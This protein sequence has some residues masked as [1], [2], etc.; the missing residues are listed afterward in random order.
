[1]LHKL[2]YHVLHKKNLSSTYSLCLLLYSYCVRVRK[3][4]P[5]MLLDVLL[6]CILQL[7]PKQDVLKRMSSLKTKTYR[8]P[9]PWCDPSQ[10]VETDNC[11][12]CLEPFNNNQVRQYT[13]TLLP[14]ILRI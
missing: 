7:L 5:N 9:K 8:Q 12:V 13:H 3:T 2:K 1:M 6:C 14:D 4:Q 10:P 11:A